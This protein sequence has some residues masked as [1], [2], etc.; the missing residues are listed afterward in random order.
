[1]ADITAVWDP[2][3]A[4]GDWS[5]SGPD[6]LAGSD[7][8]TAVL[9]SL[10]TDRRADADDVIP[11]GSGNPRGWWGDAY[12]AS[13]LGS[14]MWLLARAKQTEDT[15]LSAQDY[16]QDALQW[17]IDGGIASGVSVTTSWQAPG[18]LAAQ[19]VI[20]QPTGAEPVTLN[21]QWAWKGLS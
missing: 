12:R 13:P 19:I 20:T 18:F 2:L 7:L 6:L 17:L 21:Y 9:V 14:K 16:C 11:D 3:N 8:A 10:F 15:R 1:M 5:M 4:R